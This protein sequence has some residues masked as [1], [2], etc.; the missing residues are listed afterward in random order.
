MVTLSCLLTLCC[1]GVLWY[2]TVQ[3][4]IWRPWNVTQFDYRIGEHVNVLCAGLCSCISVGIFHH[5]LRTDSEMCTH[6]HTHTRYYN[7]NPVEPE[8]ASHPLL[9]LF[10]RSFLNCA[11]FWNRP[12]VFTSSLT[13]FYKNRLWN[14]VNNVAGLFANFCLIWQKLQFF[15]CEDQSDFSWLRRYDMQVYILIFAIFLRHHQSTRSLHSS[16]SHQLFILRHN[17]SFGSRA[18]RFSAPRM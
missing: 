8:S 5:Y 9:I 10:L 14:V 4:Y 3:L 13:Q 15:S 11:D 2:Q 12:R 18:F 16:S 7:G 6:A 17:L 1:S